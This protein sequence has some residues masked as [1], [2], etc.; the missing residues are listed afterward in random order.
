MVFTDQQIDELCEISAEAGKE[1]LKIYNDKALFDKTSMK[2]DHSPL[3]LADKVSNDLINQRLSQFSYQAP[4]ISEENKSISYE[5]R[6]DWKQF[7]LVDPLDGTKEF[8]K[9]NGQFTINIALIQNCSPVFGVIHIP[10]T[11]T[12][13]VG[14]INKGAFKI[15]NG[16][17][18]GIS[19][20]LK[21]NHL[22]AVGSSS[23][24]VQED[25]FLKESY[26]IQ[27]FIPVGSSIKFCLV[28]EGKA[29]IYYRNGPTMEWDTAAGEAILNAAGGKVTHKNTH[30]G[31]YNKENLLNES[32]FCS[33]N[34][35]LTPKF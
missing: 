29:D 26:A 15:E 33:G 32:F 20:N 9:R 17:R 11:N 35:Q 13:Y 21:P 5:Q 1:V 24:A 23:H 2:E 25:K 7:W 12:T 19:T 3:T 18:S 28:A 8:L 27:N 4:L 10:V 22:T 31:N 16:K 6:K 14:S 34:P 30:T